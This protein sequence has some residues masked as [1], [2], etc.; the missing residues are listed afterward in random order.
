MGVDGSAMSIG[1]KM[2]GEAAMEVEKEGMAMEVEDDG[3]G[4]GE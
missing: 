3:K 2:D 1:V 4:S